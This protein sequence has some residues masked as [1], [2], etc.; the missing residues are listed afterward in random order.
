MRKS[1][2][3][4]YSEMS[5]R[6]AV[7]KSLAVIFVIAATT[8]MRRFL[9]IERE[10]VIL[11]HQLKL[12]ERSRKLRNQLERAQSQCP[13]QQ[14]LKTPSSHCHSQNQAKTPQPRPQMTS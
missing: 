11:I 6:R 5:M 12:K 8:Q 3:R 7:E 2:A 4:K 13:K 10:K 9:H 14:Q 1:S